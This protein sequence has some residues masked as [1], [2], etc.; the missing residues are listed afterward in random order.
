MD[1]FFAKFANATARATGSPQAFLVC[2]AAVLRLLDPTAT[3]RETREAAAR[4]NRGAAQKARPPQ[5]SPTRAK[6]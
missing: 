5:A 3:A 1:K 6:A 4:H 2:I